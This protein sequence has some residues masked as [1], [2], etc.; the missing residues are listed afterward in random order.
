MTAASRTAV[1]TICS[2]NY[3]PFARVLLGSVRVHHPDADL[4]LCL[5]DRRLDQPG[6]YDPGWTVVEAHALPI[7]DFASF[8]FRYDIMELNTACKPFMFQHLLER[9]EYDAALYFDPDIELFRPLDDVLALLAGGASLVLTPHLCSPSEAEDEPNDL[10]IMRAGIYNLGFLGAARGA[11]ASRV[12]AWWARRLRYQCVNAQGQGLFVDQKFMDL[13]PAFA[14]A[15]RIAHDTTLNVAY[16]NLA[17]RQLARTADGWTVDG[18]PLGFFHYSGFDP[19]RP[20]RLSKHEARFAAGL[21]APLAEL[22]GQ[23]AARLAACGYGGSTVSEYAYGRFASGTPI[24]ALVRKMFRDGHRYWAQDPFETYEAFLHEPWPDA[25]SGQATCVVSNL[26]AFLHGEFANLHTRL[27]LANPAHGLELVLWFVNEAATELRLDPALIEPAAARLGTFPPARIA[28]PAVPGAAEVTVIGYLRTASGVGE[29]GRQ[30]LLSLAASGLRAEGFDVALGVA[31]QRGDTAVAPLLAPRGSAP[32]QIF[33]VNADQ[34]PAVLA[35]TRAELPSRSLRIAVPFWELSRFP[36]AWL[37]AFDQVDEVWAP[38]R[39]IQVALAGRT[40]RPVI[41][42]PVAIA[43]PEAAPVARRRFGLPEDRFLFF[44]AFDFLS[45]MARKNPAAAIAA[46]RQAFPAPGKAALVLKS[47][48]G[49]HAPAALAALRAAADGH[50][51]IVLLD[52]TLSRADT[53][54]L[55]AASDAVLSLHRSEGLGLLVAEAMLL[56]KPVIATGY[57]AVREFL[58]P[59]TGYPVEFALVPVADGDYPFPDGQIWAE[60]DVGH[61]AWLMRRLHHEPRRADAL[62]ASAREL[63]ARNHGRAQVGRLQRRRL[64]AIGVA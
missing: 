62:A 5:A 34:L 27:D 13:A 40:R 28:L 53:L 64:R 55:L 12:L 18:A 17:Q 14:P 50:P 26:M 25:A 47:M 22:T 24:P 60:P 35:H 36:A 10:T 61:A 44:F 16:W 42:I 32:L 20:G 39:F 63:V 1:F 51:D 2:N 46:F 31:A 30:T 37:P 19:A 41:H 58:T 6:F 8:A 3:L 21:D 59:R 54:G 15:A 38:S 29:A 23:Y 48:N 43:L 57:S 4:F 7:E 45:F 49:A 52:E 9:L 33:H 11:E 56:G